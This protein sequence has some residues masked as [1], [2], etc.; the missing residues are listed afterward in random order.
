ML[1]KAIYIYTSSTY[2]PEWLSS[3]AVLGAEIS[4]MFGIR[5]L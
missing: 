2:L 4:S 1:S 5:F 3:S